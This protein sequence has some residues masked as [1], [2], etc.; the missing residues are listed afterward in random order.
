MWACSF[1]MDCPWLAG[2]LYVVVHWIWHQCDEIECSTC[3]TAQKESVPLLRFQKLKPKIL[4]RRSI[5]TSPKRKLRGV[6][7]LKNTKNEQHIHDLQDKYEW[8]KS[9]N[10]AVLVHRPDKRHSPCYILAHTS[11]HSFDPLEYVDPMVRKQSKLTDCQA[12]PKHKQRQQPRMSNPALTIGQ[13]RMDNQCTGSR[14]RLTRYPWDKS[15]GIWG[16]RRVMSLNGQGGT[17]F[18]MLIYSWLNAWFSIIFGGWDFGIGVWS[19]TVREWGT[20]WNE[21]TS[22]GLSLSHEYNFNMEFWKDL[23]QGRLICP[24]SE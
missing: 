1:W 9:T 6:V 2:S 21:L 5:A 3:S 16:R 22:W 17:S 13:G 4:R 14:I 10:I 11:P 23:L 12:M 20:E 7:Q 24:A 18:S 8:N 15:H 19:L